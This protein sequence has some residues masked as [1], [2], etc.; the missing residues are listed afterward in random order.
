MI[1]LKIRV[2]AKLEWQNWNMDECLNLIVKF[3]H[4]NKLLPVR[5]KSRLF[6]VWEIDNSICKL[7]KGKPFKDREQF[8]QTVLAYLENVNLITE[9]VRQ[10]VYDYHK[11]KI[12][13]TKE[14]NFEQKVGKLI[15]N[16]NN[17]FE[18]EVEIE[19]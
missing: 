3:K 12:M 15:K 5:L 1:Q 2:K 16:L 13:K 10:M 11:K 8:N 14:D 6:S 4:P 17:S 9:D 18:I 19:D 7:E